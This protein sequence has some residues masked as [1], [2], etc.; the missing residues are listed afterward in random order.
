M[1]E[2]SAPEP[3][4]SGLPP[5]P[6]EGGVSLVR[7]GE[8]GA[9]LRHRL[10]RPARVGRVV[11]CFLGVVTAA[12][13]IADWITTRLD[14]GIALAAF[15]GVL[16]ALGVVQHLLY[17]QDLRHWPTDVVL[18]GEGIELVLSNGEVRGMMWSDPDIAL[19][20]VARR[21]P[22]P[23]ER[24]Y[25]LLW[26]PDSK[27]PAVELSSDGYD[28]IARIAADAHLQISM[29]RRGPRVGGT[30]MIQIRQLPPPTT[31]PLAKI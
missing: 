3:V 12:A 26:L 7:P 14:V 11:L 2:I 21:A 10:E 9:L 20:L 19:Q 5:K 6:T 23:A 15:G 29:T 25:L 18:W 17:Q 30:Q 31:T 27:I 24:E 1:P 8:E 4:I 13:G 28:R 22:A 16:L